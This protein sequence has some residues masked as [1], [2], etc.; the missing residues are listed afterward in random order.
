MFTPSRPVQPWIRSALLC[1][2]GEVKDP[3]CLV[4][5]QIRDRDRFCTLVMLGLAVLP[6]I[7][8]K[9]QG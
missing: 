4:L 3:V 5:Q 7:P 6:A 8:V 9:V 2:P 1:F